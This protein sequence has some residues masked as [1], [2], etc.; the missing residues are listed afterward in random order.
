[1]FQGRISV[2][3]R[4]ERGLGISPRQVFRDDFRR[5]GS[6]SLIAAGEFMRNL[7]KFI[8][9]LVALVVIIAVG[10][11]LNRKPRRASQP[12]PPAVARSQNVRRSPVQGS[13]SA[14]VSVDT[15]LRP[16]QTLVEVPREKVEE[17]LRQHNRDVASLL[18]A[19]HVLHDTNLLYEAATNFPNDPHLQWTILA[20]DAF[21]ADRR[22]W[23]DAFKASSP[24]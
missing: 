10:I 7:N 17:Y 2:K 5:N 1:M 14:P 22:K 4:K 21:P 3:L 12:P 19:F 6:I 24:N 20:E 16:G 23:L 18:A 9:G 15:P 8:V 11:Y 13:P